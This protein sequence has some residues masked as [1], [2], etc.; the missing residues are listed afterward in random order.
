[1]KTHNPEQVAGPFAM[2]SHGLEV[3]APGRVLYG[4]GQ[5][6]VDADG[7]VGDGIEE[8]ARLVWRNIRAV[9]AS[10]DMGIEH[11]VQLTM[12]LLDRDDYAAAR[13]VREEELGGHRPASTLL[14]VAGLS[15]PDWRIEIDF[16]AVAA[17]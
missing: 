16:V 1:M 3:E 14:Y 6:G 9:L 11:V 10:A 7:R 2:Y 4:A 15:N 12:Y 5:V 8:Q 17:G 13:R